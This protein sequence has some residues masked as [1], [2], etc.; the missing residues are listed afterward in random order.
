[1]QQEF[2]QEKQAGERGPGVAPWIGMANEDGIRT[3]ILQLSSVKHI[4]FLLK[5]WIC[6]N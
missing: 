3:Q 6:N 4:F 5:F 2:I 1:M